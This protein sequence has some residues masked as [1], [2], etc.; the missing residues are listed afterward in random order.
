VTTVAAA[1]KDDRLCSE[2]AP[3]M[4]GMPALATGTSAVAGS[5]GGFKF[6]VPDLIQGRPR[7]PHG[8]IR[9]GSGIQDAGQRQPVAGNSLGC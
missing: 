1:L 6:H 4:L 3:Q 9:S 7:A 5:N 2:E 8:G